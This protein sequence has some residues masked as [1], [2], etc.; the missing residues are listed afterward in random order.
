MKKEGV[1]PQIRSLCWSSWS[2]LSL[3]SAGSRGRRAGR[4][5]TRAGA[6]GASAAP[7][8]LAGATRFARRCGPPRHAESVIVIAECWIKLAPERDAAHRVCVAPRSAT[9]GAPHAA[10][11]TCGVPLGRAIVVVDVVPI[12][13]PFM[14]VRA[15]PK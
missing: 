12:G 14:D 2:E 15:D 3:A 6:V 11:G 13:A 5:R 7:Q 4:R 9:R 10:F 8:A 1:C